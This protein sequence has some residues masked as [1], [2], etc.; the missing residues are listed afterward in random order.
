MLTP[1]SFTAAVNSAESVLASKGSDGSPLKNG[2]RRAAVEWRELKSQA[3]VI[4]TRD[5]EAREARTARIN[6]DAEH[7][8]ERLKSS[9]ALVKAA[10]A[11]VS[12]ADDLIAKANADLE[13]VK[14]KASLDVATATE[15][16]A[17]AHREASA[18]ADKLESVA[19]DALHVA[20]EARAKADE[21]QQAGADK[22]AAAQDKAFSS[23]E[24]AKLKYTE[25]MD[26]AERR[27]IAVR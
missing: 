3:G 23:V 20:G 10:Q 8:A 19:L 24:N 11:A 1:E 14:A 18:P 26:E 9:E 17:V 16:A 4:A 7:A 2:G 22:L 6:L 21:V 12:D 15:R 5:A 25:D 13:L 27:L